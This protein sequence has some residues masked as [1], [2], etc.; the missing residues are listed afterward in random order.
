MS[1]LV[2]IVGEGIVGIKDGQ[3][4]IQCHGP[5]DVNYTTYDYK[6]DTSKGANYYLISHCYLDNTG[7]VPSDADEAISV[8]WGANAIIQN[9]Y[10]KNWGKAIL[11]GSG[12]EPRSMSEQMTVTIRNCVLDGNSRRHPYVQGGMRVKIENCIIKNWGNSFH[13]KSGGMRIENS[14]V[15][16]NNCLFIQDRFIQTNLWNFFLDCCR[17][18]ETFSTLKNFF[19]PGVT[20]G[21]YTIGNSNVVMNNCYKNKWWISLGG[22][23]KKPM[24]KLTADAIYLSILTD[25]PL[26]VQEAKEYKTAYTQGLL[27]I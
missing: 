5:Y 26:S 27:Q 24:N 10:I 11:L 9:C 4:G 8:V 23:N 15:E 7:I 21:L 12:N 16:V 19:T 20:R 22:Y 14:S 17:Q 25:V 2:K 18:V 3:D 13:E 6:P 1:D